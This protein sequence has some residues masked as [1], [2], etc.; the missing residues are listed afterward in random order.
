[1]NKNYA[2]F[3]YVSK[4]LIIKIKWQQ[5]Y[6]PRSGTPSQMR[7]TRRV[8]VPCVASMPQR[9]NPGD[10]AGQQHEHC[11]GH[12]SGRGGRLQKSREFQWRLPAGRFPVVAGCRGKFSR[13]GRILYK[14]SRELP[15]WLVP[16]GRVRV[17][18]SSRPK[19]PVNSRDD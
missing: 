8:R 15:W 18:A 13:D 2:F 12:R 5:C 1:M 16:A 3:V 17:E 4:Y 14:K 19:I 7:E 9:H 11:R 10:R 6:H